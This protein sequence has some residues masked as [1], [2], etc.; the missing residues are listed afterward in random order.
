MMAN[1]SSVRRVGSVAPRS[2]LVMACLAM[3][4]RSASSRWLIPAAFRSSLIA[5]PNCFSE[6]IELTTED[7]EADPAVGYCTVPDS[8]QFSAMYPTIS[9]LLA[10]LDPDRVKGC[11]RPPSVQTSCF[12]HHL[13]RAAS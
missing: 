9:T 5:K 13:L 1:F 11:L 3:P 6:I 10:S 2:I 8:L 12:S 7:P 4:L